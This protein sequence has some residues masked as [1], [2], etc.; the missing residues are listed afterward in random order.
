MTDKFSVDSFIQRSADVQDVNK[1]VSLYKDLFSALG[2]E[3]IT[4]LLVRRSFR[5]IPVKEGVR[6]T[7]DADLVEALFSPDESIDFDPEI[8]AMLEKLEPFHWFEPENSRKI[9]N[10]Q[11]R[12][13]TTLRDDGFIDGIAV[14]VMT[15]PG[16]L[17]V[18]ALSK[19]SA[20]F[21]FSKATLRKLQIAC[22]VMHL[23]FEELSSG[24][25]H[26]ALSAR[27]TEVMR[28]VA[29]GKSNREIAETLRLSSHTIDTLLRRSFS[30][31]GVTNRIEASI[32]FTF[33][34]KLSA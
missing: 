32:M 16:E 6:L 31:L 27:E 26:S 12:V 8:A 19:R 18:F 22:H 28:L 3:T 30:K 11:K 10:A 1:L 20:Q 2:F 5:S 15:R 34:D 9:S 33:R 24:N 25:G 13:F 4:Y 29:R 21:S 23:R 14:P 7:G 17:A